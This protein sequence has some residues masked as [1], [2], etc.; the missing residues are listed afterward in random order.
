VISDFKFQIADLEN[1]ETGVQSTDLKGFNDW[2]AIAAI[3]W[4]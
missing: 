3:Q 1:K 4:K 2:G